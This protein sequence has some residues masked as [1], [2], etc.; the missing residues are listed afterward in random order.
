MPTNSVNQSVKLTKSVVDKLAPPTTGQVFYRDTELK[1][2]GLRITENGTK[3]F[4]LEKRIQER[5]A[6][7]R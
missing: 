2:F 4:I 6:G 5:C 1:G 3:S 7:S